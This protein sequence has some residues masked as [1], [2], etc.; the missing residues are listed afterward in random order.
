MD[1][2]EDCTA[3]YY[4]HAF[5]FV[6]KSFFDYS[7]MANVIL[8]SSGKVARVRVNMYELT[9]LNPK[10]T[11]STERVNLLLVMCINR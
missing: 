8:K 1:R 6:I 4:K 7:S 5:K 10:R 9:L 11:T 2:H 3:I